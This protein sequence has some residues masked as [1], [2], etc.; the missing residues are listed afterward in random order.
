MKA[1]SIIPARG[2]SKKI[3]RKNLAL[4]NGKPLISYIIKT[5]LESDVEETLVS[6]EDDEILAVSRE[7][8]AKTIKRPIEL[9][10]D[11]AT[12]ESVLLHFCENIICEK[13]IF[14]QATSPLTTSEDINQCISKLDK[15]DT[16]LTVSPIET[17]VWH[18]ET[19]MYDIND[20][21]RTQDFEFNYSIETGAMFG[22][23]K[24]R[25]VKEKNRLHGNIGFCKIPRNRSFDVDT[26]E[27]LTIVRLLMENI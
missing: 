16:V 21:K 1:I 22:M 17:F 18:N 6:S 27:D 7:Y 20:R 19:A 10:G 4:I 8:G 13:L 25:F 24:D 12:S 5:S 26:I 15:H 3:P 9:A 2:G 23:W 14:L 11:Y